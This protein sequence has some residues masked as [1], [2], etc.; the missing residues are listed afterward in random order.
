MAFQRAVRER[1]FVKLAVTGPSGSG[2]TMGALKVARGIAGPKGRI[3]LIDTENHSASLYADVTPFDVA[4]L[5]PPFTVQRY[6]ALIR[7]AHDYDVIVVDSITHAWAGEGGLLAQKEALDAKGGNSF[8]NWGVITKQHEHFKSVLLQAPCHI[9][10]TMRS[11]EDVVQDKNE[12]GQVVVRK[13]GL[14]PIQRDGMTYEFTVVFDVDAAH[15]AT[16]S[17]D[18][19]GLFANMA[20]MLSEADGKIIADWLQS[21]PEQA[22]IEAVSEKP[23]TEKAKAAVVAM[24]EKKGVEVP[25]DIDTWSLSKAENHYKTLKG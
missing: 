21:A 17:K 18:R 12:R 6:E 1:A 19:T 23:I 24:C 10:A 8:A 4:D 11:K 2:K 9:I 5:A 3:A 25:A 7:E 22:V 15:G 20:R 14:S 13:V 16:A